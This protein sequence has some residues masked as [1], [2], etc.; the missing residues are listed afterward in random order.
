CTGCNS[1]AYRCIQEFR[2]HDQAS[3]GLFRTFVQINDDGLYQKR[4]MHCLEP[5]CVENC[6][7]KALTKSEYG[8]VLYDAKI[9]IG[10]QTCVRVCKFHIPQFD[11]DKR[12]IVKCSMCAQRTNEGKMPACVEVCPTGALQ[13]GE[14]GAMKTLAVKLAKEKKLKLYGKEENGGTHLFVLA[15]EDPV[16][17]GYPKVARKAIKGKASLDLDPGVPVVAALA[18]V[19][20]KKYSERR[21]RIETEAKKTK[22]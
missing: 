11:A 6:P 12:K 18:V 20:F 3:K 21:S 19:G 8:P 5:D 10:C 13:F 15:K 16:K 22:E 17:F 9:C 4:C 2:Y 7:V 14:Y 1:C